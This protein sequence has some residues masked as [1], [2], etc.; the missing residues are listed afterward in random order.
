[1]TIYAICMCLDVVIILSERS[2]LGTP[3]GVK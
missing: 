3:G 2:L 1:M